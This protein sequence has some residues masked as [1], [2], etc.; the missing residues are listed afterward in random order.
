LV[1]SAISPLV[2]VFAGAAILLMIVFVVSAVLIYRHA[3][4]RSGRAP[5]LRNYLDSTRQS[6]GVPSH[7]K[8]AD[9]HQQRARVMHL[10]IGDLIR[11]E[12]LAVAVAESAEGFRTS[13]AA[14]AQT[15]VAG[16]LGTQ[17]AIERSGDDEEQPADD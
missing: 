2:Y 14:E 8:I 5:E 10:T 1:A 11:D 17:A 16:E 3:I 13:T 7:A 15:S 4:A 12:N 9:A 6:R